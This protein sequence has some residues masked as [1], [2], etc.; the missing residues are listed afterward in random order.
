M[1][2]AI[3]ILPLGRNPIAC[4]RAIVDPPATSVDPGGKPGVVVVVAAAASSFDRLRPGE[5]TFDGC[6]RDWVW[7]DGFLPVTFSWSPVV[8]VSMVLARFA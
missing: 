3:P 8:V 1:L 7:D 5:F 6:A 2:L 4:G